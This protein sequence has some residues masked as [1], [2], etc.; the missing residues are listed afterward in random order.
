LEALLWEWQVANQARPKTRLRLQE[1]KDL[2]ES[3]AVLA[4]IDVAGGFGIGDEVD[5]AFRSWVQ[6]VEVNG[7]EVVN[8]DLEAR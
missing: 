5:E 4:S 1:Y 6:R 3:I 7:L 2:V 8:D